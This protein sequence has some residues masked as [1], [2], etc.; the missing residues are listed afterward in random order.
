MVDQAAVA[1]I[2]Q[3]IRG[4]ALQGIEEEVA[5]VLVLLKEELLNQVEMVEWAILK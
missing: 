5:A 2:H 4:V 1:D 3:D